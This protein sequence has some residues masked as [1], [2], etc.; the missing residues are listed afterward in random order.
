MKKKLYLLIA[1]CSVTG[2]VNADWTRVE[3]SGKELSL[4]MLHIK[5]H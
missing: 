3:H 1:L 4:Y 2:W 5:I